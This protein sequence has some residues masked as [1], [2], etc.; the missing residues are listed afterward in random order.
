MKDIKYKI[1]NI[2]REDTEVL[3]EKPL[4]IQKT[5]NNFG[6]KILAR[7]QQDNTAKRILEVDDV[8]TD[9]AV[10]KFFELIHNVDPTRAKK[11]P[12]WILQRYIDGTIRLLEDVYKVTEPLE[13]FTKFKVKIKEAG[14][15][16]DI[17]Q[18]KSL[19]ELIEITQPFA[20]AK[21][22]KELK[23]GE[24]AELVANGEAEVLLDNDTYRVSIPK[25]ANASCILGRNTQWCTAA[26]NNNMFDHYNKEGDMYI[27]LIKKEDARYQFHFE[28]EQFM[29]END[30]SINLYD[31]FTTHPTLLTLIKWFDEHFEL[32]DDGYILR[33]PFPKNER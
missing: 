33:I 24:L 12:M 18:V 21:T 8:N 14:G 22:G 26:K 10:E 25:T 28:S 5:L 23:K 27:V 30:N 4:D 19:Q 1:Y 16:T 31:F 2:L 9:E 7:L 6:D 20:D 32:I 13:I 11:Y 17:N 15:K 29:D 3:T